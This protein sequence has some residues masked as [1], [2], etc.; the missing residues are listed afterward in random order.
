MT[1]DVRR[2]ARRSLH[3]YELP[4]AA[5]TINTSIILGQW[6][7]YIIN[8]L[9]F[10][11]SSFSAPEDR[12]HRAVHGEKPDQIC[13]PEGRR[14]DADHIAGADDNS[15]EGT[16]IHRGH[17]SINPQGQARSRVSSH[18]HGAQPMPRWRRSHDGGGEEI[19]RTRPWQR[20]ARHAAHTPWSSGGC[21]YTK[22][23]AQLALA[24]KA[25]AGATH[26]AFFARCRHRFTPP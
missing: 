2:R 20:H 23:P 17:A 25:A 14:D 21:R 19:A 3:S 8:L 9:S 10:H 22:E 16:P 15:L 6:H 1:T 12:R 24:L 5:S 13:T 18:M 26:G 4:P 11:L 7:A